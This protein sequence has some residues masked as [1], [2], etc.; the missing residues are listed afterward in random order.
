MLASASRNAAVA[1]EFPAV[2]EKKGEVQA[3][4]HTH[5]E[6]VSMVLPDILARQ[7]AANTHKTI[8]TRM[9]NAWL[10]CT[11][12]FARRPPTQHAAA[13]TA[14]P[15][16]RLRMCMAR[17]RATGPNERS[18]HG[19]TGMGRRSDREESIVHVAPF[20]APG[21]RTHSW[22]PAGRSAEKG[23]IQPTGLARM[24]CGAGQGV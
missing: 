6:S 7:C 13:Q 8:R 15:C 18:R 11:P 1:A 2:S 5:M 23:G 20:H 4:L 17:S 3:A 9:H 14:P 16:N 12:R 21:S 19:C 22:P 10:T 24:G